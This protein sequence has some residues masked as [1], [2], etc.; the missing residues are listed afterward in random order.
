MVDDADGAEKRAMILHLHRVLKAFHLLPWIPPWTTSPLRAQ[1]S[2]ASSYPRKQRRGATP[3]PTPTPRRPMAYSY[4]YSDRRCN[5]SLCASLENP[6]S[7][8]ARS[9]SRAL[10]PSATRRREARA[11]GVH[12]EH[13]RAAPCR[14][15]GRAC[16]TTTHRLAL[17]PAEED[18]RIDIEDAVHLD[19]E[20][21]LLEV[22][23]RLDTRSLGG[24]SRSSYVRPW[25]DTGDR[26]RYCERSSDSWSQY[27]ALGIRALESPPPHPPPRSR[28]AASA[29]LTHPP[30]SHTPRHLLPHLLYLRHL[31]PHLSPP[32]SLPLP[33]L[34]VSSRLCR[35][36]PTT[37]SHPRA[38]IPPAPL[39]RFPHLRLRR[40]P[41]PLVLLLGARARS[42]TH[43]EVDTG[44][45]LWTGRDACVW[46]RMLGRGWA[47]VCR[48]AGAG[49]G[50]R[51][52][53]DSCLRRHE[54][55]GG[56]GGCREE[57]EQMEEM[58]GTGQTRRT[59][60]RRRSGW[61]GRSEEEVEP[62]QD[63]HGGDAARCG[64]YTREVILKY[65]ATPVEDPLAKR[66]PFPAATS[67]QSR[68]AVRGARHK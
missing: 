45:E 41:V 4:P 42:S 64:R 46:R 55:D 57:M 51:E 25:G 26:R 28:R 20:L 9:I 13:E 5:A 40:I 61:R 47:P 38:R 37:A 49:A 36:T 56:D 31:L 29:S 53:L 62:R 27:A 1:T 58:A 54:G 30:P 19:V 52:G 18:Q 8:L 43:A 35:R 11:S 6:P 63:A 3:A 7:A 50:G 34:L 32:S 66:R 65:P 33:H 24:S 44:A 68:Y 14:R 67:P 17:V 59:R 21:V 16:G 39:S 10:H 2:P 15:Q 22:A 48:G 12:E 23:L 60:G